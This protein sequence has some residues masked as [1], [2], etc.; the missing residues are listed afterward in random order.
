MPS[1]TAR[2]P[3]RPAFATSSTGVRCEMLEP[4]VL[5]SAAM[6]LSARLAPARPTYHVYASRQTGPTGITPAEMRRF[7]G[8]DQIHLLGAV[9]GDGAGQT[10][11]IVDAYDDPTAFSDLQ[12]FDLQFNLPDP[13]SFRQLDEFGGTNLPPT[14]PSSPGGQTWEVEESLDVQWAHVMA[15]AANIVL[16]EADSPN[17]PDFDQAAQ[18]AASLPGVSVV[19][20]S[21]GGRETRSE[22]TEDPV[23][24]T[25]SGH[26]GVTFFAATGDTGAPGG[27]PA[28]SPNVVAV[29]GTHAVLGP[30]GA[31]G[32]ESAW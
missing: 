25:P 22:R 4:R 26:A 30:A 32:S 11:A 15:P 8:V 10:I 23:F 28:Y 29:G 1:L 17:D 12:Q 13:P 18:T 9:T 6:A 16:V 24:T 21:F 27:Y 2:R 3:R 14:D 7:Y 5:F 19:S 31:Y 20:M